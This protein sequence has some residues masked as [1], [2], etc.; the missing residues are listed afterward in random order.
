MGNSQTCVDC[1]TEV[2]KKVK[3]LDKIQDDWGRRF[4]KWKNNDIWIK[5]DSNK[6][7]CSPCLIKRQN[8]ERQK[9]QEEERRQENEKRK[10][11]E[12]R[13]EAEMQHKEMRRREEMRRQE[14]R[15]EEMRKEEEMQR[16][17]RQHQTR[18]I[19]RLEEA[20]RRQRE[21][22]E[23][24]RREETE[25]RLREDA[26]RRQIE[27]TERRQKAEA[28]RRRQEEIERRLK[29][30]AQ[31]NEE[32]KRKLEK[33]RKKQEQKRREE[34]RKLQSEQ[35]KKQN[36]KKRTKERMLEKQIS[37][38]QEDN[39]KVQLEKRRQTEKNLKELEEK[40]RNE[41]NII[42]K[43]SRKRRAEKGKLIIEFKRQEEEIKHNEKA[44][45]FLLSEERLSNWERREKGILNEVEHLQIFKGS[46]P[47]NIFQNLKL[48]SI[49]KHISNSKQE[50]QINDTQQKDDRCV[51]QEMIDIGHINEDA[52]VT[53]SNVLL[54]VQKK[55]QN[56]ENQN[57]YHRMRQSPD[58]RLVRR[59]CFQRSNFTD[60]EKEFPDCS[61]E[62][63]LAVKLTKRQTF[64]MENVRGERKCEAVIVDE[65][66]CMLLDQGVHFTYLSHAV[67]GMHH[68]EP[69]L[70]MIWKHIIKHERIVSENSE[71]FFLGVLDSLLIVLS[72]YIDLSELS[73]ETDIPPEIQWL[74]LF[75]QK[76]ILNVEFSKGNTSEFQDIFTI[77]KILECLKFVEEDFNL[78]IKFQPYTILNET[79]VRAVKWEHSS[80][81]AKGQIIHVLVVGKGLVC[82]LHP[83]EDEK[84]I[85]NFIKDE[86]K[87]YISFDGC[88][89]NK[90]HIPDYLGEFVENRLIS[91]I[92]NAFTAKHMLNGRE[93][94]VKDNDVVP[95][96]F[97]S[98]GVVQLDTKWGDCLH[99]FLEI[100]HGKKLSQITLVTNFM[101]NQEYFRRYKGKIF[102]VSGT[103]GT[104]REKSFL[105]KQFSLGCQ[106]IPTHRSKVFEE[107]PGMICSSKHEWIIAINDIVRDH[108]TKNANKMK[109]AVLVI[110]EDINTAIELQNILIETIC[111]SASLYTGN[112]ENNNKIDSKL[113]AGEVIVAT[114][115][116][117]RGTDIEID[118]TVEKAGGL[119][120]LVT[121]L[122]Q[123]SRIENQ[124]FGRSAR[125]GQP[126]SGQIVLNRHSLPLYFSL[127]ELT[128]IESVK[129]L[130]DAIEEK[131]IVDIEKHAF[132]EVRLKEKL[133][134]RYCSFLHEIKQQ[135]NCNG[136]DEKIMLDSLHEYWGMWLKMNCETK[137]NCSRTENLESSLNGT[138]IIGKNK[139]LRRISPCSNA[140]HII[141]IANEQLFDRNYTRSE[142]LFTRAININ[143][144]WAVISFYNRAYCSLLK[145]ETGYI[146]KAIDDLSNSQ[147]CFA[148]F[149]EEAVLCLTLSSSMNDFNSRC[150][151]INY[152]EENIKVS[153]QQLRE[154]QKA[155]KEVT[156]EGTSIFTIAL[157]DDNTSKKIESEIYVFWEMGLTQLLFVKERKP[158]CWKGMLVVA[159]GVL[160]ITVGA[161]LIASTAG[162]LTQL[163]WGLIAEGVND[164]CTG[165]YA[166]WKSDQE[167][168]KSWMIGKAVSIAVS[169]ASF[170]YTQAK[171]ATKGVKGVRATVAALKQH[172][173][174]G[175]KKAFSEFKAIS[176]MIT[177]KSFGPAFKTTCVGVGTEIGLQLTRRGGK[178]LLEVA[179]DTVSTQF[180]DI[181]RESIKQETQFA[182]TKGEM[183]PVVDDF[184][185]FYCRDN[186]TPKNQISTKYM[187]ITKKLLTSEN[188]CQFRQVLLGC[189]K[190]VIKT[191][192]KQLKTKQTN[193]FEQCKPIFDI[194]N[195]ISCSTY[196]IKH[197]V[198]VYCK[199]INTALKDIY[200]DTLTNGAVSYFKEDDEELCTIKKQ[201][202]HQTAQFLYN[203]LKES[204]QFT[205][206][207]ILAE[208]LQ[209]AVE[210]CVNEYGGEN[211]VGKVTIGK[212]IAITSK[213][214]QIG[215]DLATKGT[216][217]VNNVVEA[218]L[219]AADCVV[220]VVADEN[221]K[222]II[223]FGL[224]TTKKGIQA[225]QSGQTSDIIDAAIDI[226]DDG[227][228][229]FADDKVKCK[230]D[231]A[232]NAT[233]K[234]VKSFKS[235]KTEDIFDAVT[236][237]AD[238]GID[239]F[240]DD[241]VK[242]KAHFALSATKKGVKAF[243]SGK[244]EDIIDAVTDIVD[245]GITKFA[246]VKV[247]RKAHFALNA[248]K[249]GV[250]AFKSGK[251]EDIVDAVT[252]IA[253]D[254]IDTF[255]DDEVKRK[256]HFVLN[257][258]K[259][260]VIAFKSGITEDIIDA[261]IDIADDGI[262]KF[263]D[264]KV[265]RKAHFALNA[266]KKGK[267]VKAFKSGKTEDIVDAVT[268]IAADGIDKFV[269]EDIKDKANFA[270]HVTTK[271][272]KALQSGESEKMIDTVADIAANGIEK[273]AD[274]DVKCQVNFALC[275]QE[276]SKSFQI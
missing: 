168:M 169:V 223:G 29:R 151:I 20:E 138:L 25:R 11:D 217:D 238:D 201:I 78:P 260:G 153:L 178:Y 64:L 245:D 66:D 208:K 131:R 2:P 34:E 102:G 48:P 117:G 229:T 100:K 43:E 36:E 24:R 262:T 257:A 165:A 167:F 1:S 249:K 268:D 123:N 254:G 7:L 60:S 166:V 88:E 242:R 80:K 111:A 136:V 37:H 86:I 101:S 121:F 215:K 157:G 12:N 197:L 89:Q 124:V 52:S 115:I 221:T 266:T 248:T 139:L 77:E 23:R 193:I 224:R 56:Y 114:N 255:A 53:I 270:L 187:G 26:E 247:R 235:G 72:S 57:R 94:L 251:A 161:V 195:E 28:E 204:F 98:T 146:T 128:C 17:K 158:F 49:S 231:F 45:Q 58:H 4:C 189:V 61:F 109:R 236:D 182:F 216:I 62:I 239:T 116:A 149:K 16:I 163:G 237:I 154:F 119:F 93:Y 219:D 175:A 39:K 83:Y 269:D 6:Y 218:G 68:I 127:H 263:A 142:G 51:L 122:P 54:T 96:D 200:A 71:H 137:E 190:D 259:K 63:C 171:T 233:K 9:L 186:S 85:H 145:R 81:A 95:V 87:N 143:R 225:L 130:R 222:Q 184:I 92:E 46:S 179:Q 198:S 272:I 244:T 241:E 120:V 203:L 134:A 210:K 13:R 99:Q 212:I 214:G 15:K 205:A 206:S 106:K 84:E 104:E 265:K 65:V 211:N 8:Q 144:K 110:C 42:N 226:A 181:A 103:L 188:I 164:I 22:A 75:E 18:K 32:R 199:H 126:G 105:M 113:K 118:E 252:D 47:K 30:K 246:D 107:L 228:D 129:H 207:G 155:N 256:A 191:T 264:V 70:F 133:F 172:V 152:F 202:I 148:L 276:R 196:D 250:K 173:K 76:N 50:P 230:A 185:A 261:V 55:I 176:S 41:R 274:D 59:F 174:T 227:I 5:L 91:W 267:G 74:Y 73:M 125:K 213:A 253:D 132:E 177:S 67:P 232:L 135:L 19:K 159:L 183:Y 31:R 156:T 170:G 44:K 234:G 97:E 14:R 10:Q 150:Q 40:H 180:E 3:W 69:I 271:G 35:I 21:E 243:K 90:H 209:S 38:K 140:S 27:E 112:D 162:I 147:E 192:S 220:G 273:F 194:I 141:K 79:T 82:V 240:A 108:I 258:T 33:E 275:N 160:Q